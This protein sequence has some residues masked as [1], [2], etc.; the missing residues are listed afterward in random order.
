MNFGCE[1]IVDLPDC[2]SLFGV[3]IKMNASVSAV[4]DGG[5]ESL[6]KSLS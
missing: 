5:F 2:V 6:L 1:N 4:V 3:A